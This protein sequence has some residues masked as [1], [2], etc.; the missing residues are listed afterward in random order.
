MPSTTSLPWRRPPPLA[1]SR[2]PLLPLA[3]AMGVGIWVASAFNYPLGFMALAGHG[4]LLAIGLT[5][6]SRTLKTRTRRHL[7]AIPILLAFALFGFWRAGGTESTHRADHFSN[8]LR[9]D[10]M[11]QA[12]IFNLRPGENSIRVQVEI[13]GTVLN[14]QLQRSSGRALV[15]LSPNTA[16][17]TLQVGDR[18]LVQADFKPIQPP[19]NPGSFDFRSYWADQY[20]YHQTFLRSD[21][22]W[23]LLDRQT[24][25]W[26]ERA[27]AL[28]EN[29]I[30]GFRPHLAPDELAVAAALVL[31]KRDLIT[32]DL[33]SAYADTGAVHV[34]AVSGLH[35]GIVAAILLWLFRRLLPG[36]KGV[37]PWLRLLVC[38]AGIWGFA[39]LTGFSPSVQRAALMFS[40]LLL[41]LER[42][43]RSPLFNSLALAA[44]VILAY[45]PRQLFAVGFQLSFAAVAGIGLFQQTISS[46]WKPEAKI[47]KPV[48]SVMSVSLAAQIGTLPLVMYYFQQFPLYFL[49]SGSI[50]ILTAY[51]GLVLGLFHGLFAWLLPA[52]SGLSG[53]LLSA[54]LSIQN[55]VVRLCRNLPGAAQ[56]LDPISAWQVVLIYAFI[57]LLAVWWQWRRFFIIAAALLILLGLG[58]FRLSQVAATHRAEGVAVLHQYRHSLVEARLGRAG[59]ALASEGLSEKQRSYLSDGYRKQAR[60]SVDTNSILDLARIHT[61]SLYLLNGH[62]QAGASLMH[63]HGRNWLVLSGEQSNNVE[64]P[65][66]RKS[67]LKDNLKSL[68]DTGF[69][70]DR[71]LIR[72]DAQPDLLPNDWPWLDAVFIL[73]GSNR[74]W[75]IDAWKEWAEDKSLELHI[76]GEDGAWVE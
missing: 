59:I 1:W 73:D 27:S 17:S 75:R 16:S 60:Y 68:Q 25:S 5:F 56:Q 40:L 9:E 7:L 38:V 4:I 31:G 57:L 49:L 2:Y 61:D 11:Y 63:V 3:V 18:L 20:I 76:T 62:V 6:T 36:Q 35:V 44:I 46:W 66:L 13:E 65:Y 29:W 69:I 51:G 55:S 15:Y 19:L 50:V 43:R 22:D 47:L 32:E 54:D 52:V 72:Q 34:L 8:Y 10:G 37:M 12:R 45:D 53:A 71:I 21:A 39:L 64:G 42:R 58:A 33:R 41:G 26:R 30:D 70:I 24:L 28:R 48:W 14:D 67:N 74:P 23:Q